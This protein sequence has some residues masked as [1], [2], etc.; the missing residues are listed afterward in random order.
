MD[1]Y[2]KNTDRNPEKS[3]F[4][5]FSRISVRFD[6]FV[7]VLEARD[8]L[9]SFLEAIRFFST[10]YEPVATLKTSNRVIFYVF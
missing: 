7:D 10:V 3:D 9:K 8:C 6:V 4:L 5:G 2:E 1:L